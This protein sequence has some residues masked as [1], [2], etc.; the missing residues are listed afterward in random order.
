MSVR[1]ATQVASFVREDKAPLYMPEE[2]HNELWSVDREVYNDAYKCLMVRNMVPKVGELSEDHHVLYS[3]YVFGSVLRFAEKHYNSAEVKTRTI[4][5]RLDLMKHSP[6]NRMPCHLTYL[7][8]RDMYQLWLLWLNKLQINK[9][10]RPLIAKHSLS[11]DARH[12]GM[13]R[14]FFDM[15]LKDEKNRPESTAE[16]M[17]LPLKLKRIFKSVARSAP[18]VDRKGCKVTV[19]FRPSSMGFH[20]VYRDIYVDGDCQRLIRDFSLLLTK[21]L[22]EQLPLFTRYYKFDL[23]PTSR[24]DITLP[25][26][27]HGDF[28]CMSVKAVNEDYIYRNPIGDTK[29]LDTSIVPPPAE[30][31]RYSYLL[32]DIFAELTSDFDEEPSPDAPPSL[33]QR[34]EEALVTIHLGDENMTGDS[35][36][37]SA[38]NNPADFIKA[39]ETWYDGDVFDYGAQSLPPVTTLDLMQEIYKAIYD[40]A[41]ARNGEIFDFHPHVLKVMNKHFAWITDRAEVFARR[42]D[43]VNGGTIF[44]GE[45]QMTWAKA[46]KGLVWKYKVEKDGETK[47]KTCDICK[48]WF[49]SPGKRCYESTTFAPYPPGH[50][51]LPTPKSKVLNLWNGFKWPLEELLRETHNREN[52]ELARALQRHIF[53][54]ICACD[55]EKFQFF[56]C[57]LAA[58][59]RNPHFMPNCVVILSGKEGAG[60]SFIFNDCLLPYFSSNGILCTDISR[61]TGNFNA[62][63]ENKLMVVLDEAS[64]AGNQK[65]NTQLKNAVTAGVQIIDQKYKAQ[66]V[67][68][69][70]SQYW[71][72]SNEEVVMPQGAAARRWCQFMLVPNSARGQWEKHEEYFT[73]L[74]KLKDDDNAGLKCWLSQFHD[75]SCYPN[76]LLTSYGTFSNHTFPLACLNELHDQKSFSQKPILKFWRNALEI[77]YVYPP[78]EDYHLNSYR[79]KN[80]RREILAVGT[81]VNYEVGDVWW[82]AIPGGENGAEGVVSL[83]SSF[84]ASWNIFSGRRVSDL[85]YN[86]SEMETYNLAD[87]LTKYR[88]PSWSMENRWMGIINMPQAFAHFMSSKS[89][90]NST[91]KGVDA[92]MDYPGFVYYSRCAFADIDAHNGKADVLTSVVQ[93]EWCNLSSFRMQDGL[94]ESWDKYKSCPPTHL[95]GGELQATFM[96]VGD[97]EEARRKFYFQTGIDTTKDQKFKD[98]DMSKRKSM[99][100]EDWKEKMLQFLDLEPDQLVSPFPQTKRKRTTFESEYDTCEIV[101][102]L[103][104]LRVQM[105]EEEEFSEPPAKRSRN[106]AC[107]PFVTNQQ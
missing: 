74:M 46:Y 98:A 56:M 8:P 31:R 80:L 53:R 21:F 103:S 72:I 35:I 22:Q 89:I 58:K 2:L 13:W 43:S 57:L 102:G 17:A 6:G 67:S 94:P 33:A 54:I 11:E 84:P 14:L 49:E 61:M 16:F 87:Y 79:I 85:K 60:K 105:E 52:Q 19:L 40:E 23:A 100:N 96:V 39:S 7:V 34:A 18:N 99:V 48:Y 68:V 28:P 51:M 42:L 26:F 27:Y 65:N 50:R 38:I 37:M 82:G 91:L 71:I 64:Y 15:D 86:Q 62:L 83:Y 1:P 92:N 101:T 5:G 90:L 36:N 81:Q 9:V 106:E 75:S 107:H 77:G 44:R 47:T 78:E 66:R 95:V 69:S 55:W 4:F 73:Y 93:P 32:K 59:I 3:T 45:N 12:A 10:S 29:L 25:G 30:A 76:S 63:F 88:H 70:F 41:N 97:W 104:R 20:I 24:G